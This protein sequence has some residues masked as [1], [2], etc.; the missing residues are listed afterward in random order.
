MTPEASGLRLRLSASSARRSSLDT[1]TYEL[2][3]RLDP[4]QSDLKLEVN[5]NGPIWSP[6]IYQNVAAEL[7][8]A[9]RLKAGAPDTSDDPALLSRLTDGAAGTIER[10][11]LDLSDSLA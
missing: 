2:L 6:A 4:K 10:E 5:V 1:P 3:V 7:A 8:R 11:N 9:T